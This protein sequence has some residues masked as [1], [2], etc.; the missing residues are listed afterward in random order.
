[1]V[2][3]RLWILDSLSI[4]TKAA[5]K[6]PM[7]KKMSTAKKAAGA[8]VIHPGF[9]MMSYKSAMLLINLSLTM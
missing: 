7:K 1:M 2:S 4:P 5:R 8:R 3:L 9:S 6:P